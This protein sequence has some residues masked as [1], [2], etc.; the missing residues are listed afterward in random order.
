MMVTGAL[1]AKSKIFS[2]PHQKSEEWAW[3]ADCIAYT[4]NILDLWKRFPYSLSSQSLP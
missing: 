3:H 1:I 4:E 2:A